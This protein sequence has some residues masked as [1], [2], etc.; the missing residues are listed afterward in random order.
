MYVGLLREFG[1]VVALSDEAASPHYTAK[2]AMRG[3]QPRITRDD[4][5]EA[6]Q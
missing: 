5:V 6:E 4:T 2:T 3:N 1:C